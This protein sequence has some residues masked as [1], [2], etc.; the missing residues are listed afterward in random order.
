MEQK[1]EEV[2][3]KRFKTLVSGIKFYLEQ[4]EDDCT[5]FFENKIVHTLE[6]ENYKND[7]LLKAFDY[8]PPKLIEPDKGN[9]L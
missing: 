9:N 1:T 2:R 3:Q 6:A 4:K 5:Y 7:E 8:V